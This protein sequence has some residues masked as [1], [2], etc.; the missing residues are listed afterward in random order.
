MKNK[1]KQKNNLYN[2]AQKTSKLIDVGIM[3]AII[4]TSI[5]IFVILGFQ[6]YGLFIGKI[7]IESVAVNIFANIL[8]LWAVRELIEEEIKKFNGESFD[9]SAFIGLA[10]AAILRKILILSLISTE[11]KN[12][13]IY[14]IV[15][16]LLGI[17]YFLMHLSC[18]CIWK[19]QENNI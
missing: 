3:I 11:N 17:V 14:G 4:T 12:I 6:V 13:L 5:I 7:S 9:L 18:H 15:I 10:I 1:I 19:W 2:I 16:L 8:I